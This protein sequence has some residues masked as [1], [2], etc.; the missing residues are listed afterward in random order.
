MTYK[1]HN[2]QLSVLTDPDVEPMLVLAS[3]HRLQCCYNIKPTL[4]QRV[5]LAV[6]ISVVNR[7]TLIANRDYTHFNSPIISTLNN[8][9]WR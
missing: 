8:D 5:L 3:A 9:S 4:V 2:P 7:L 1:Q 6:L